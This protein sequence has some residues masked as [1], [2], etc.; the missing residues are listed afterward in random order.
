MKKLKNSKFG[1]QNNQSQKNHSSQNA[2][3][4]SIMDIF[5]YCYLHFLAPFCDSVQSLNYQTLNFLQIGNYT[6]QKYLDDICNQY[7]TFY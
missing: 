2:D 5:E 1:L 4:K 6:L 7:K 3:H